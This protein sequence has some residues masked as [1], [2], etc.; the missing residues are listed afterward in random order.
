MR[1]AKKTK[2]TKAFKQ[3]TGG[4]DSLVQQ[5]ATMLSAANL[6]S[7][8]AFPVNAAAGFAKA[9]KRAQQTSRA[10]M[11]NLTRARLLRELPV[12][13][14]TQKLIRQGGGSLPLAAAVPV[15]QMRLPTQRQLQTSYLKNKQAS[16]AQERKLK[17]G[18]RMGKGWGQLEGMSP[19][20]RLNTPSVR[21]FD[22]SF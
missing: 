5:E 20:Q 16:V 21:G 17:N 19:V 6:E 7:Q 18:V 12:K 4:A 8:P 11:A 13:K 14:T 2:T 15:K 1:T 10:K 22:A 3:K 9:V